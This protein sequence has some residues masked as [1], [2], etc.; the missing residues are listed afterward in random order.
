M[1][2]IFIFLRTSTYSIF[3]LLEQKLRNSSNGFATFYRIKTLNCCSTKFDTLMS[4][5]KTG[6]GV[7]HKYLYKK[8]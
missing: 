5:I 1:V 6:G 3:Q 7:V 4:Y 8:L 2:V